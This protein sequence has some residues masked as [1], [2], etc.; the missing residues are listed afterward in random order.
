MHIKE[1]TINEF[2]NYQLNHALSSYNQTINYGILMAENTHD[3]DLI[4]YVDSDN[5][6]Y[7]ASLIIIKKLNN[8]FF[9]GYAPKGF[10]IDYS[11]ETLLRNFTNDLKEYYKQKNVI[12]I[13][14]NPE[15]AVAEIDT[16]K[17]KPLYNINDNITNILINNGYKKLKDNLYFESMI[18][19]F[20]AFIKTNEF[21]INNI[22]KNAKNKIKKGIR[23]GLVFEKADKNDLDIFYNFIKNKKEKHLNYYKD[24]YTVFEKDN[25][26]DLFLV[27]IDYNKFLLNSQRAYEEELEKNNYFN[28]LLINSVNP[29]LLNRKMNSDKTLLVYKNDILEATKGMQNNNDIYIAGA[30][31]VTHKNKASII[32]SGYDQNYKRFVPNYFLHYNIINYYYKDYDFIDL[33]GMTGDFTAANPYKGLNDFK[34]SFNPKLFEFIG[35]FD[36]IIDEFAYKTVLKTGL[37]AREF[38]KK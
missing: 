25:N 26:I 27:K 38:N 3:Y 12:F 34:L 31:V 8:K 19:R 36:L 29:K 13:K 6:I 7:A 4:G 22:N 10:L 11:N 37:L 32:M 24:F 9:Y 28:E 30:L 2:T 5:N 21:N 1:L 17:F 15:I 23:K 18:P 20:N 16:V 14:I 35:E 33:N